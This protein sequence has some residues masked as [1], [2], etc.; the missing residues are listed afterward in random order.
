MRTSIGSHLHVSRKPSGRVWVLAYRVRPLSWETAPAAT[1]NSESNSS[2]SHAVNS[3]RFE[4]HVDVVA[5]GTNAVD[6]ISTNTALSKARVKHAMDCGAV[7]LTRGGNTN[8]LRRAKRALRAGDRLHLYYDAAVLAAEVPAPVLVADKGGYSIWDK[9][10]RLYSQGSKWGDHCTVTR[11]AE[12]HLTPERNAFVVHRLDRAAS[13]L[14]M[15]AH[16]KHVAASLARLF[17]ERRI[18]KH[19]RVYAEGK[20]GNVGQTI[21]ID[22]PIDGKVARSSI[23]V[24]DYD[25]TTGVSA[26][27]VSIETGR[28]HQ[29]RLHLAALGCPTVGDRLYGAGDTSTDL[30]L[31]AYQLSF[32]CP[33]SDAPVNFRI[34]PD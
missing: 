19:Y 14:I 31:R 2:A 34:D 21:D 15:I 30:R 25:A 26:L 5:A 3:S 16:H 4:A 1:M 22:R 8:R 32:Q 29:I 27:D 10:C 11:Y 23:K 12:K 9:P 6:L 24:L 7:W 13:G 18:D 20:V 28:K 17:R 33:I